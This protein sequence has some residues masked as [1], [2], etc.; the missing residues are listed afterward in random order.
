MGYREKVLKTL[1]AAKEL[2]DKFPGYWN[3][4]EHKEIYIR[5]KETILEI[6]P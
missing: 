3:F 4:E 1:K 2:T 5:I 6:E